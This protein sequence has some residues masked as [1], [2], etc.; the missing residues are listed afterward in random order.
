VLG[1]VQVAIAVLGPA[2]ALLE[3]PDVRLGLGE[4]LHLPGEPGISPP[5]LVKP[6]VFLFCIF[7]V[8]PILCHI[9]AGSV[10]RL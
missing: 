6:A 3:R 9:L 5:V 8:R 2:L 4:H 10:W 7:R 1:E